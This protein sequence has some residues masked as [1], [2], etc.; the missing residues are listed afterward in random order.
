MQDR[1]LESRLAIANLNPYRNHIEC[2]HSGG[3]LSSM[4]PTDTRASVRTEQNSLGSSYSCEQ[5]A[6]RQG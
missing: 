5:V 4:Q 2:L 1:S 3:G 6:P